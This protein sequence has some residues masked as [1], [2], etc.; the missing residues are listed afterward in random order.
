MRMGC[1]WG[2][3]ELLNLRLTQ[4]ASHGWSLTEV[5]NNKHKETQIRSAMVIMSM[6]LGQCVSVYLYFF[7]F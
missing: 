2:L 1:G 4:P 3:L 7:Q 6:Y 5:G